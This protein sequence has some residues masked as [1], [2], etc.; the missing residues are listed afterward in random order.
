MKKILFFAMLAF[1]F[2]QVIGQEVKFTAENAEWHS[3]SWSDKWDVLEFETPIPTA[4]HNAKAM[5]KVLL[6]AVPDTVQYLKAY[7]FDVKNIDEMLSYISVVD[8]GFIVNDP[9]LSLYMLHY[10]GDIYAVASGRGFV[11]VVSDVETVNVIDSAFSLFVEA[12]EKTTNTLVMKSMIK[13]LKMQKDDES[14]DAVIYGMKEGLKAGIQ[15]ARTSTTTVSQVGDS[16][17]IDESAAIRSK[18]ADNLPAASAKHSKKDYG[19]PFGIDFLWGF[20]NWGTNP[21]SGLMGMSDANYNLR[22]SFSSY[23]LEAHYDLVL[24]RHFDM[25]IG[26]GYESDI[27]KFNKDY[28]DYG[29]D[30]FAVIDTLVPGGYYS[31]RFVTRYVQLPIHVGWRVRESHRSFRIRIAAIPAL[32]WCGKHT[33]LKHEFHTDGR[34]PQDQRNLPDVVN[35]FKLDVRLQL[36][37]GGVGVFLQVA[38]MPLF[39]D[40]TK[41]Y[42]IKLGFV[43]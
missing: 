6:I 10:M 41:I 16:N 1:M 20:N 18:A 38:T 40:G 14:F 21:F 2:G 24:T 37:F 33:G 13:M 34:N 4:I 5:G 23:Q 35:P 8:G 26:L 39:L 22:T 12:S 19:D 27:Y 31:S 11:R 3:E 28:V 17:N 36:N 9:H 42:P 7:T 32:G 15:K 43:L 25:G 29:T 30:A